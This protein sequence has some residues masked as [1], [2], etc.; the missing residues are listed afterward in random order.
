MGFEGL[1]DL[2]RPR[3]FKSTDAF[4][5]LLLVCCCFSGMPAALHRIAPESFL[6]A[7]WQNDPGMM[8]L[9]TLPAANESAY[10]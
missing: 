3:C 2:M 6:I 7:G 5:Q 10:S 8:T 1:G 9:V 4:Q